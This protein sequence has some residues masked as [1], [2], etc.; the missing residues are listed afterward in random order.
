MSPIQWC[1]ADWLVGPLAGTLRPILAAE[2]HLVHDLPEDLHAF[3]DPGEI[4][5]GLL[6]AAPFLLRRL[7]RQVAGNRGLVEVAPG[8][9]LRLAVSPQVSRHARP[10]R[11]G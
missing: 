3:A 2:I 9:P 8:T 1:P 10:L 11:I 6:D 5:H 7:I 4:P